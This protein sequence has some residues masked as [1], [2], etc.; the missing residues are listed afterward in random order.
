MADG[1]VGP[2]VGATRGGEEEEGE[3]E[4][5]EEEEGEEEKAGQQEH[6]K[7]KEGGG[8]VWSARGGR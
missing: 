4:E 2:G 5:E 8:M 6:T 1:A 7:G 3:G